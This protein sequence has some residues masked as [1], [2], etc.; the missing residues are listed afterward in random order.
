[1]SGL[2]D[3]RRRVLSS[4]RQKTLAP[5]MLPW[6]RDRPLRVVGLWGSRSARRT[7]GDGLIVERPAL[8]GDPHHPIHPFFHL[9]VRG[10]DRV[11]D[12]IEV[13]VVR[14]RPVPPQN[15]CRLETQAAGQFVCGR[16][17]PMQIGRLRGRDREPLVVSRQIRR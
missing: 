7:R 13:P 2:G 16:P 6:R 15:P 4:F 9:H 8:G 10:P 3:G 1:M 14:H 11:V 17:G 5:G 12:L